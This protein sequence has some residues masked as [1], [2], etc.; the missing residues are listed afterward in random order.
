MTDISITAYD[1][2]PMIASFL[3][4]DLSGLVAIDAVAWHMQVRRTPDSA[5]L[6]LD[7]PAVGSVAIAGGVV[8]FRAPATAMAALAGSYVYDMG[9][10][11]AGEFCRV[12]GGSFVV[13]GGVT[14]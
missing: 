7:V 6:Y 1:N 10:R 4:E 11:S 14:R 8:T 13:L 3:V 12:V 9:F 2:E 5:D